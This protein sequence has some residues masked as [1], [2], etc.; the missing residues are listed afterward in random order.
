MTLLPFAFCRRLNCMKIQCKDEQC[1]CPI[2]TCGNGAGDRSRK[3][4]ILSL[5]L[6]RG[7]ETKG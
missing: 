4:I 5:K 2:V 1:L 6:L 3:P 7:L